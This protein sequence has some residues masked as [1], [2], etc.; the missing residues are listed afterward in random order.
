MFIL[1]VHVWISSAQ[2]DFTDAL[3][4]SVGFTSEVDDSCVFIFCDTCQITSVAHKA[5]SLVTCLQLFA[6]QFK[7]CA[8][9]TLL[10]KQQHAMM[11]AT[12]MASHTRVV[13]LYKRCSFFTHNNLC[14]EMREKQNQSFF[15]N[16]AIQ[17]YDG[18]MLEDSQHANGP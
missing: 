10:M 18:M 12:Y 16:H 17:T 6:V 9:K 7:S 4:A 1:L 2:L 8:A 14:D 13:S 11:V 5:T 3:I 15:K